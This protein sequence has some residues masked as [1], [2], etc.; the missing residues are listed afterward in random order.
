MMFFLLAIAIW[1]EEMLSSSFLLSWVVDLSLI[2]HGFQ[3]VKSSRTFSFFL[4]D[5][6]SMVLIGITIMVIRMVSIRP[7][8]WHVH[9]WWQNMKG[10]L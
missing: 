10:V 4:G 6:G 5:I 9:Q 7:K 3:I 2:S 8:F 1:E